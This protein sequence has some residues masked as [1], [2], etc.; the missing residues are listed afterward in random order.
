M[1]NYPKPINMTNTCIYSQISGTL[2]SEIREQLGRT[3]ENFKAMQRNKIRQENY[4]NEHAL[5][6]G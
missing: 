5:S 3:K 2:P 1:L 6:E 4:A